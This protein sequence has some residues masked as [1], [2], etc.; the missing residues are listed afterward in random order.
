MQDSGG[1]GTVPIVMVLGSCDFAYI[2]VH[3]RIGK[4][5]VLGEQE[6][7]RY[8]NHVIVCSVEI[9]RINLAFKFPSLSFSL[10]LIRLTNYL[11]F[12]PKYSS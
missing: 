10:S 4:H 11:F 2:R 12:K 6:I 3:R 9:R 7:K 5:R 1:G 8:I